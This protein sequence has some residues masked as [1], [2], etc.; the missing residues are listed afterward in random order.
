MPMHRGGWTPPK[1][2]IL[3]GAGAQH[4]LPWF[5]LASWAALAELYAPQLPYSTLPYTLPLPISLSPHS[6]FPPAPFQQWD[7]TRMLLGL[8]WQAHTLW[9]ALFFSLEGT[10]RHN[11]LSRKSASVLG[12]KLLVWL[13]SWGILQ[14]MFLTCRT[15][16]CE[17]PLLPQWPYCHCFSVGKCHGIIEVG[18]D[19][20]DLLVHLSPY[21]QYCPLSLCP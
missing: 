11:I 18:K 1:C 16:H 5:F 19:F 20:E 2:F 17:L 14:R 12:A 7:K 3:H 6:P 15:Q 8:H 21:H 10:V 9:V 4:H 13:L